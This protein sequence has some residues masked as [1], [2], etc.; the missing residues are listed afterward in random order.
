VF[1]VS[2]TWG[3]FCFC[4]FVYV[5]KTHNCLH[6]AVYMLVIYTATQKELEFGF[7][8]KNIFGGLRTFIMKFIWHSA[9]VEIHHF[10]L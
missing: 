5:L 7:W 8:L 3:L 1:C 4:V 2:T 10:V 6:F 9:C